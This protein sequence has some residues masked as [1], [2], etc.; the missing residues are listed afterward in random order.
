MAFHSSMNF[1]T[2]AG[3]RKTGGVERMRSA[4]SPG[5]TGS[6]GRIGQRSDGGLQ[7]FHYGTL[8]DLQR[9]CYVVRQ[10]DHWESMAYVFSTC[11]ALPLSLRHTQRHKL[12]Y[13]DYTHTHT[14]A[15]T[16]ARTHAHAH[17][18]TLTHTYTHTLI[19]IIIIISLLVHSHTHAR[20]HGHAHKYA[21]IHRLMCQNCRGLRSKECRWGF[22]LKRLQEI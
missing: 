2:G 22:F 9:C 6:A 1:A 14:H 11:V 21:C 13:T 7:V 4:K 19:I 17:T 15:R 18:H 3:S 8:E 12:I 10:C 5:K 20:T 16:H